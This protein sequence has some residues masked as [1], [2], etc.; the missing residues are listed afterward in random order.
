MTRC[1]HPRR[2][3][4]ERRTEFNLTATLALFFWAA[5]W[6]ATCSTPGNAAQAGTSQIPFAS[7]TNG[8]NADR[9]ADEDVSSADRDSLRHVSA[10]SLDALWNQWA[11]PEWTSTDSLPWIPAADDAKR[12]EAK[13]RF[14]RTSFAP[15]IGFNKVNGPSAGLGLNIALGRS[16]RTSLH[17]TAA[18]AFSRGVY[19]GAAGI[20][21]QWNGG[22]FSPQSPLARTRIT[23]GGKESW[24]LGSSIGFGTP[25]PATP[26]GLAFRGTWSRGA[27]PFGTTRPRLNGVQ[28]LFLGLDTQS[29]LDREECT[30]G[31]EL[32]YG[33]GHH[34]E[35]VWVE[36]RDHSLGNSLD[37]LFQTDPRS[38][39]NAAS[40]RAH[41]TG[42]LL[43]AAFGVSTRW[44]AE[45]VGLWTRLGTFETEGE[46]YHTLG[47]ESRYGWVVPGAETIDVEVW[48]AAIDD[49]DSRL[50]ISES[51][52]ARGSALGN[53]GGYSRGNRVPVQAYP[54]LGGPTSLRGYPSRAFLGNRVVLARADYI[55]SVNWLGGVPLV[56]GLR[57]QP[58]LFADAGGV[59]I[60][61]APVFDVS[62]SETAKTART[63]ETWVFDYG[64]GIQRNVSYPGILSRLRVDFAVR[65]DRDRD[66]WRATLQLIR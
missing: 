56:R 41:T 8:G 1:H 63:A 55:A 6:S 4:A 36:Q 64:I 43:G 40:D 9:E 29:Y 49:G 30:A 27:V 15:V 47:A 39:I 14:L 61:D 48:A 31:L 65:T 54:D 26:T 37:P 5:L 24:G 16:R 12:A 51:G 33:S 58:V 22:A 23:G 20:R 28:S 60:D 44:Y 19:E 7:D 45:P 57:L 34:A 17:G 66:R 10:D 32:A 3:T 62:A 42:V 25:R 46:R 52:M 50:D 13:R 21:V 18:R 38:W 53:R 11:P 35:L 59:W 2:S